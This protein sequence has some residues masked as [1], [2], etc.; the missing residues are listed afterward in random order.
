MPGHHSSS[1]AC[2]AVAI[3]VCGVRGMADK[4]AEQRAAQQAARQEAQQEDVVKD[5]EDN[6]KTLIKT[7]DEVCRDANKDPNV[8]CEEAL[9][10]FRIDRS[11]ADQRCDAA[12][13]K[14]AELQEKLSQ[15]RKVRSDMAFQLAN[16]YAH[17]QVSSTDQG[18][19]SE[20]AHQR[21]GRWKRL[22][23]ANGL[24][25]ICKKKCKDAVKNARQ[26]MPEWL[27][28]LADSDNTC[29]DMFQL[30]GLADSDNTCQDMFQKFTQ[31]VSYISLECE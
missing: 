16:V 24:A 4:A 28:G 13:R 21:Q 30:I 3:I 10:S 26:E 23:N 8:A 17:C 2:A 5:V 15:C 7:C 1:M 29:Q 18:M 20:H 31:F 11:C 9:V 27:V 19:L 22:S 12:Q 6:L 25:K 14:L